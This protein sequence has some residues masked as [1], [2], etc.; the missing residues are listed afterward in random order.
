MKFLSALVVLACIALPAIAVADDA[1]LSSTADSDCVVRGGVDGW[2]PKCKNVHE[3]QVEEDKHSPVPSDASSKVQDD[4]GYIC[5]CGS[6][7]Q[8]SWVEKNY[9]LCVKTGGHF[10]T[11]HDC[12]VCPAG[13]VCET[14]FTGC[15]CPQGQVFGA[16]AGCQSPPK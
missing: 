6:S 7:H 15:S 13:A 16:K 10:L 14:C 11:V 3:P 12:P 9:S 1:P 4:D 8:C 2:E 5:T